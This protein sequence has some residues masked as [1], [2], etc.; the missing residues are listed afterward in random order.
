[1]NCDI[2]ADKLTE[3]AAGTL[4]SYEEHACQAHIAACRTCRDALRGAA[5]MREARMLDAPDVPAGLF[6]RI[7]AE[8]ARPRRPAAHPQRFWLGAAL[9]GALAASLLAAAVALGILVRPVPAPEP[10]TAQFY[11]TTTEARSMNI[12]IDLD[13]P[14]AGARISVMLAGDVE[15][16]GYGSL[17]ELSWNDDLEAGVNKLT[18]PLRA[19]G[20]DVGQ[21]VVR[22]SHPASE[23]LFVI[24]LKLDS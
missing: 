9:G 14:L 11:V 8:V 7:A 3:L 2:V 23:Q 24:K 18:L 10:D 5:A 13:R 22:L 4:S 16:E 17:R 6:G 20:E 12:A 21:V 15:V 19:I 1:M